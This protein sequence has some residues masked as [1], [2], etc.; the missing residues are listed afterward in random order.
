MVMALDRATTKP[1][2]IDTPSVVEIWS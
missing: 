1:P 2:E